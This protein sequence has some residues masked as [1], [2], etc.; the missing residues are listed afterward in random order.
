MKSHSA[1]RLPV[2]KDTT[3]ANTNEHASASPKIPQSIH[4]LV[5][6][7]HRIRSVATNGSKLPPMAA[8]QY[9]IARPRSPRMGLS[10]AYTPTPDDPPAQSQV[11][12]IWLDWSNESHTASNAAGKLRTERM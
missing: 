7:I 1:L 9:T 10:K 11:S 8:T 2:P 12:A 3:S 4:L 5:G 6:V